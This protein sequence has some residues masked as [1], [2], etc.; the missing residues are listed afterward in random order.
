M[1]SLSTRLSSIMK[2]IRILTMVKKMM[3]AGSGFE[4]LISGFPKREPK[5]SPPYEPR[6][7][8]LAS[9]TRYTRLGFGCGSF[10]VIRRGAR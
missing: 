2:E 7:I 10:K 5:A 1:V 6:G 8:G 3:V 9:P 4:P